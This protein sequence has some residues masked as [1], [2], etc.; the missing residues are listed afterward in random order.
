MQGVFI[1]SALMVV[2]GLECKDQIYSEFN[3]EYF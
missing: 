2:A 1:S 3:E